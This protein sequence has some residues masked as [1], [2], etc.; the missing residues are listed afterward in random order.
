MRVKSTYEWG[1]ETNRPQ[2][3]LAKAVY[4]QPGHLAQYFAFVVRTFV[5]SAGTKISTYC[6]L[7]FPQTEWTIEKDKWSGGTAPKANC[8][9]TI[10]SIKSTIYKASWALLELF[11]KVSSSVW[12]PF[13]LSDT[14]NRTFVP[15]LSSEHDEL[16]TNYF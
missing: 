11:E 8:R 4:F 6:T 16:S 14:P 15:I 10:C 9:K 12:R 1:N 7:K 2:A 3:E 13:I 5:R